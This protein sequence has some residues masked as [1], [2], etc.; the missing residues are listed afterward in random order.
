M[1]DITK[2]INEIAIKYFDDN[3]SKFAKEMDTSEANIRNYRTR[4][5]PKLEFLKAL[6]SKLDI[7][8]EWLLGDNEESPIKSDIPAAILSTNEHG[9][10]KTKGIPLI[11]IE[12]MAGY[13]KGDVQILENDLSE[14]YHVPDF[15]QK[16]AKYLIRVSG[17]S[18]YPKYSNGDLLACRPVTDLTFFQW[19][20]V[21]VLDTDQGPLVKRLFESN[22]SDDHL[23]CRS[24]N[25]EYY[26]PF[27]LPK[28][29]IRQ[30]AIVVGVIRLD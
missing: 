4:I 6:H 17:N 11:P 16:G 5:V 25:K 7:S 2:K 26:P 21:Y 29:S 13:G 19:G 18:M 8:F 9:K 1:N 27:M 14:K 10:I 30:V 3:N 24:D 15:A 23:E 22:K 20:K 12:A 28:T